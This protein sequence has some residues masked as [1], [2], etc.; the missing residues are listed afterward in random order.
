MHKK[1]WNKTQQI[2]NFFRLNNFSSQWKSLMNAQ[3]QQME[4]FTTFLGLVTYGAGV[5]NIS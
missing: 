1:K 2:E 5:D 4:N 3:E